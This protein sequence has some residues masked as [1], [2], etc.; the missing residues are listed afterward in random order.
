M[1]EEIVEMIKMYNL[2]DIDFMGYPIHDIHE[3]QFHHLLIPKRDC[4]KMG[5]GNGYVIWNGVPLTPISHSY[6]HTIEQY[7]RQTFIYIT[8]IMNT[9]KYEGLSQERIDIIHYMLEKF[10]EKFGDKATRKGREIIKEEFYNRTSNS[11]KRKR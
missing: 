1:R 6:L 8:F 4:P 9:M 3:L 2:E 5:L 7:D 11:K 10:E